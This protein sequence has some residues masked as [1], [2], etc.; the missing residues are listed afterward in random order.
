MIGIN[1]YLLYKQV[2]VPR[3]L[4][5]SSAMLESKTVEP[6][7]DWCLPESGGVPYESWPLK[8]T[9]WS[10]LNRHHLSARKLIGMSREFTGFSIELIGLSIKNTLTLNL[11]SRTGE[12]AAG[13]ALFDG[14]AREQDRRAC[15]HHRPPWVQDC[16]Q[17]SATVL[18]HS[19]CLAVHF[20]CLAMRS[21]FLA[22]R[23]DCLA[24]RSDC[25][26]VCF[27]CLAARSGCLAVRSDCLIWTHSEQV[28]ELAAASGPE[29]S[30]G[31]TLPPNLP[32]PDLSTSSL[33]QSRTFTRG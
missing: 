15:R 25:L 13:A 10:P 8:K 27:D 16:L 23:S 14:D 32:P 30:Q 5:Y 3:V 33:P 21:D 17:H 22:A 12:S 6:D 28:A 9:S 26:D 2:K 19:D 18:L 7:L 11:Q 20:D 31:L 24:A 4:R 1:R 29:A